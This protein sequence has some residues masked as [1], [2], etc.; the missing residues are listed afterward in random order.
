MSK[1]KNVTKP[2]AEA[3]KTTPPKKRIALTEL[4]NALL[5]REE[6]YRELNLF[7]LARK[8]LGKKSLEEIKNHELPIA[9][10]PEDFAYQVMIANEPKIS[11][12]MAEALQN[13]DSQ[14]F[15]ELSHLIELR[16]NGGVSYPVDRLLLLLKKPV[17][18]RPFKSD[19]KTWPPSA[20]EIARWIN[21]MGIKCVEKTV[22]KAAERVSFKLRED[23][24]GRKKKA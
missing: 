20:P 11:S 14:F 12:R 7:F 16:K 4:G 17:T 23:G 9:N 19:F 2:L 15:L 5:H 24:S 1:P 3:L 18:E 22:R 21:S 13:A 8:E 6:F 10:S